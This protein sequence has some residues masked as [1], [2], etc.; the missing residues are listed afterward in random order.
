MLRNEADQKLL[1]EKRLFETL[2]VKLE[3]QIKSLKMDHMTAMAE[4]EYEIESIRERDIQ[5]CKRIKDY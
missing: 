1:S 3:N 4:K 2:N 5:N